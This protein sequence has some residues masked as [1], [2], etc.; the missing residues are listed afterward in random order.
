MTDRI[1]VFCSHNSVDKPRVKAVAERLAAAGID[2]WVDAWEIAPGDNIVARINEGLAQ[3]A[4]GLIF[5]SKTTLEKRWVQTEV[6]TLTYQA[7]EDGK[8][9][10]PV[11]LDPDAPVPELLRPRAR[12]A[13]EDLER[14]IDAIYGRSGKPRLA[15]ARTTAPERVLRIRLEQ[16]Q[17][18]G[19]QVS[20][21]L[22]GEGRA[23]EPSRLAAVLRRSYRAFLDAS[24]PGLSRMRLHEA[25]AQ[26]DRDLA[27]LGDALGQA[28]LPGAVGGEL[29]AALDR[30]A[31]RGETLRL[32]LESGPELLGLP[33][34]AVRL[35]DG[36]IPALD[37]GVRFLRRQTGLES[38]PVD[39][40]P[41]PMRILVAVG[42]PDEDAS[43]NAVLDYEREL[44]TILD[45]IDHARRYGNAEVK[46]LEV[47]H[48]DQIHRAV[49]ARPYHVLH[50]SGHG[51][52][53]VIE[54]EDEDGRPVSVTP[55]ELAASLRVAERRPPLIFV[56]SCLSGAGDSDISGFAQG[57]LAQ[58]MPF[59]IAM[60]ASVSDWYATRLAGALY[61]ELS[62]SETPLASRAL[63]QARRAV[64]QERQEALARG[65]R[66]AGL[67]PEY[68][69]PTLFAAAEERPLV[70]Y[71]LP[72]SEPTPEPALPPVGRMPLLRMDELIGR[73]AAL[74]RVTG[75][76]RGDRRI[77]EGLGPRP[78]VLISGIGGVG[79]SALAG[80]VMARLAEDGW[81]VCAAVGRIGLG[82]LALTLG[83]QL[84]LLGGKLVEI[85]MLL[86]RAELPDQ[87]RLAQLQGLLANHRLL[88]VLDNFEDNLT[89]GGG[90]FLEKTTAFLL[91]ALLQSARQGKVLITCRYPLPGVD[92]WLAEE[93]LGPLSAAET[94]KLF[95]RLPALTGEA[96]ET[97]SLILRHIG[98]H[99]R[100]LEYLDAILRRGAARL[101]AVA[102]GLRENARRLGLDPQR[103]GGDLGTSIRDTLRL[104]AEDVL[105]DQLLDL[106]GR[107]HADR[108]VLQQAAAFALP[109]HAEGLAFA[110]AD[111]EPSQDQVAAAEAS[112]RRLI[113]T[114]LLTPMP[115]DRLWVHR[116]TAQE[117]RD[118][119]DPGEARECS[120][121]AGE[122]LAWR[123]ANVSHDLSDGI[124]ATHRFLEAQAFDRAAEMAEPVLQFM[125]TY[126][127]LVDVAAFA[128]AVLDA[129]PDM[130]PRYFFVALTQ[131]DALS[132]LGAT[133][134]AMA[135]YRE[136]HAIAER[137]ARAEPGRA[138]YQWGLVVSL[139]RA[140]DIAADGG[141]EHLERALGILRGL[142]AAGALYPEQRE[143]IPRLEERLRGGR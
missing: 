76:L 15:P 92:V 21:M 87:V 27:R 121:R 74:R 120:R 106:V 98:G 68:A 109:V 122:Y 23:A 46:I 91:G 141:S 51:R 56:A 104:G 29:A 96:P 118:R 10:I 129:L 110:L 140:A 37:P 50:L 132:A 84:S 69:T 48:P 9:V 63:A 54:L 72:R 57:L 139:W 79:K 108:A 114:S 2:P 3:C 85:G 71:G 33:F 20:A 60:Q 102:E 13:G 97:L 80:R 36:R 81:A 115:G 45:A 49:G 111:G 112:A 88:L 26:R 143:W 40:L 78:G 25:A 83:G 99:P 52:A 38:A 55:A 82:E 89:L 34:E 128:G 4:V 41:G 142:D 6:S 43:G 134:Q 70:D 47:G 103:L 44:S 113:G 127:Q 7:I 73:R 65:G 75:I 126:G 32:E 30:T 124:E 67:A 107:E 17:G 61:Q 131:G 11:M 62:A 14:L 93:P 58:G 66:H 86:L 16:T 136:G 101:P 125:R 24:L 116:W 8:A 135:R 59:V 53:G 119:M 64:E 94:R 137:L 105:L 77:S 42:A 100:M 31:A 12:V 133:D 22:D 19:L 1:R 123:A 18:D 28:L 35:P 138:D 90:G 130:H 39:P 5:F 95:Y 117:I